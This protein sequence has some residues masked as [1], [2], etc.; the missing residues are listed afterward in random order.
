VG[1]LDNGDS[2]LNTVERYSP[3]SNSWEAVASM[4]TKRDDLG[5]A[6]LDGHLYAVGGFDGS[7][8]L[9][10]VERYSPASNSWEAVATMSTKRWGLGV[11]VY[12]SFSDSSIPTLG[13]PWIVPDEQDNVDF[14]G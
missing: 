10:T 2:I 13:L 6:V 11:A 12:S 5:V 1:G 4:S 8:R 7:S 14:F 9:N 3:A